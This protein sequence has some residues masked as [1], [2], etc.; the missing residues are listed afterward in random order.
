MARQ[1]EGDGLI[2]RRRKE[3]IAR[4]RRVD[5]LTTKL[6]ELFRDASTRFQSPNEWG[7][8]HL[9]QT[10]MVVRDRAKAR[11]TRLGNDPCGEARKAA[12]AFLKHAP[13]AL[14]AFATR[15]TLAETI[16]ALDT[17]HLE[18]IP[19]TPPEAVQRARSAVRRL[20]EAVCAVKAV[21]ADLELKPWR[22]RDPIRFV[23]EQAQQ[24]WAMANGGKAPGGKNVSSP[25]V[26]FL[27]AAFDAAGM[28]VTRETV[29]AVLRGKRRKDK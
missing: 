22:D 5:E 28:P 1:A 29:S 17:I 16:S 11:K 10:L 26:K 7:C 8:Y 6:G 27:A 18:S 3:N 9:A 20:Q 13:S 15:V 2:E 12:G 14:A 19:V 24:A 21:R 23:A 4:T 25:L